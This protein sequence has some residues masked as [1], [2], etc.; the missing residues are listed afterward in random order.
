MNSYSDPLLTFSRGS[1]LFISYWLPAIM[2]SYTDCLSTIS[3]VCIFYQHS[4]CLGL[5]TISPHTVYLRTGKAAASLDMLSPLPLKRE[6]P[7]RG[8]SVQ[9]CWAVHNCHSGPCS[10]SVFRMLPLSLDAPPQCPASQGWR[11]CTRTRQPYW[12][13][14]RAWQSPC[15][16]LLGVSCF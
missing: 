15:Q 12:S 11:E 5:W 6:G 8:A 13:P 14:C 1:Y 7:Q 2:C 3:I 10:T 16:G 4:G 9:V